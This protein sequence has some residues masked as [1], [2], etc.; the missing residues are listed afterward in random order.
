[1]LQNDLK[2]NKMSQNFLK[3]AA[4]FLLI[5]AVFIGFWFLIGG[6]YFSGDFFQPDFGKAK[7]IHPFFTGLVVPLLTLGSSLL[8]IVTLRS[9]IQQNFANNFFKLID[10]HHK[11]VDNIKSQPGGTTE[12]GSPS[13]GRE[14]FDDLS[15]E[16]AGDYY[17]LKSRPRNKR[18]EIGSRLID[19]KLE[20]TSMNKTGKALLICIYEHYFS[21]HH[22]DLGHYFR[23]L[24]HIVLFVERSGQKEKVKREYMKMLRAQLSNYEILLLAYNG[25]HLKGREFYPLIE[26]YKL[27]KNLNSESNLSKGYEKRIVDINILQESYEHLYGWE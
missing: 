22:S 12:E 9:N 19:K 25:L 5:L 16:I 20:K 6:N 10:Q 2:H 7:E 23:N 24:Y 27:L 26:K 15:G 18:T 1:M 4:Y 3:V 21:I 14:F 17:E 13:E 8:V 11:L